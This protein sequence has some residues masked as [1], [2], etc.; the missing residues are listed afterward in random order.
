[1]IEHQEEYLGMTYWESELEASD[2]NAVMEELEQSVPFGY[3]EDVEI[4]LYG[5]D[6][7]YTHTV[8]PSDWLSKKQYT[9]LMK[10]E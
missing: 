1:M 2:S 5:K 8:K 7:L 4:V 3:D 9:D 10:E 6:R